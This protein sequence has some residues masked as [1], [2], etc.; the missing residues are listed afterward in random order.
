MLPRVIVYVDV[1]P[2]HDEHQVGNQA[3]YGAGPRLASSK[4]VLG[5]LPVGD[6]SAGAQEL[7]DAP[8][9]SEHG[10]RDPLVASR[11]SVMAVHVALQPPNVGRMDQRRKV[12]AY[13][14]ARVFGQ[15]VEHSCADQLIGRLP[16]ES[17]VGLVYERE[18]AVGKAA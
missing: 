10:V 9:G 17:A 16:P 5:L 6:V 7:T 11:A 14:A 3:Q 12:R 15:R 2:A 8:V 18:R 13:F 1:V 4:G